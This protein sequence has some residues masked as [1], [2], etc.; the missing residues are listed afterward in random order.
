MIESD[1]TFSADRVYR[2]DL[3]RVWD[4]TKPLRLWIMLNPSTADE[5][6][7]DP[8]V[9]RVQRRNIAEGYGGLIVCNIFALRSTDPKALYKHGDPIGA[10][11]DAMIRTW[12]H[13]SK[14]V[15]CAWGNHG[16]YLD[17]GRQVLKMI[18]ELGVRPHVLGLNEGSGQPCHPLYVRYEL[19][20]SPMWP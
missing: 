16:Q 13:S 15:V 8:T 12:V 2:W 7:N 5:V 11:N 9:E 1:A 3:F 20:P 4:A 14:Q 10:D 6:D 17:R 18:R 19:K